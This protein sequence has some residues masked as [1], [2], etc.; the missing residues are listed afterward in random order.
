MKKE[1]ILKKGEVAARNASVV[2]LFFG[3]LKLFV[4]LL[5]GSVALL[6]DSL[7]SIGDATEILFVWLGFKISQRKPTEKFPYGFYKAENMVA[8]V[9]S[10]L[11]LYV[12][13]GVALKSYRSLFIESSLVHAQ[14]AIF[15]SILDA[16]VIYMLGKYELKVGKEINAQSLIAEGNESRLHILFSGLVVIGIFFSSLGFPRTEGIVG[17]LISLLIFKVGI[18][19]GISSVYSLMDVSPDKEVEEKI[20]EILR[21]APH[22]KDFSNLRL[23]KSGPFIFG[24]VNVRVKKFLEVERA[25]DIIDQIEKKIKKTVSQ[26]DSFIIHIEPFKSEEQRI[27]IPVKENKG[28]NSLIGKH[29][30]RA[31]FFAVLKTKKTEIELLDIKENPFKDK[32]LRAGL[33]VT[34][35]LL[36]Q[37]PDILITSEIGPIS[38]NMLK[39]HL[40]EV[41]KVEQG[42]VEQTVKDFLER[43]LNKLEEPT[44]DKK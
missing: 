23:R 32:K 44:T 33:S 7:H 20:K 26:V 28:L 34:E 37:K 24:E 13:Y 31:K 21:L 22:V 16:I 42:T 10:F 38:F 35:Y 1:E 27:V 3:G 36:E 15:V 40:V 11:I 5:S 14:I 8:L 2:V 9:V 39:N 17:L 4:G 25:H 19:S 12:G 30:A 41:Y 29:F 43:K 18:D 6:S